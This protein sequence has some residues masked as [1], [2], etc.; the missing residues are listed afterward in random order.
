VIAGCALIASTA[1]GTAGMGEDTCPT[2]PSS[3]APT[4]TPT[5]S[6]G[7]PSTA[8]SSPPQCL[9]VDLNAGTFIG[10]SYMGTIK[11][12]P[13]ACTTSFGV[14]NGGVDYELGAK[15]CIDNEMGN[16]TT[17]SFV[18]DYQP[19][20]IGPLNADSSIGVPPYATMI[21]CLDT[22]ECLLPS[23][24]GNTTGD[25]MAWKPDPEVI[26]TDMVMTG[27]GLLP[28]VGQKTFFQVAGTRVCHYG[29]GSM[30]EYGSAEQCTDVPWFYKLVCLT[31]PSICQYGNLGVISIPRL[32]GAPG[33]SGGPLY[34]YAISNGKAVGVYAVGIVVTADRTGT[35]FVPMQEVENRLGVTL[36]TQAALS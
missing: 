15:H 13:L 2:A 21:N 16:Q 17:N 11:G 20:T 18:G 29:W 36:L 22:T 27:Q 7:E 1:R 10:L 8:T 34:S 9:P 26:V 25:M 23:A 30:K 35:G 3:P 33:D 32:A 28:V 31:N 4:A 19:M 14:S 12:G 6:G 5:S 24:D